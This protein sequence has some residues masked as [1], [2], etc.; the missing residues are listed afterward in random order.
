[1]AVLVGPPGAQVGEV[2]RELGRLTGLPVRDT[3]TDVEETAGCPVAEIFV[4]RGEAEFR[5]LERAAVVD[6]LTGH[7]GVLALG[8]GAVTD[9]RTE[10]DLAGRRVVFLDVGLPDAA[11]RLGFHRD[12]PAGLGN[13][14]AQWLSLMELRRP[15]YQRLA[16]VTVPTDGRTPAEVA[17]AVCEVLGLPA[18]GGTGP[19]G[20]PGVLRGE[21][22]R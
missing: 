2:A 17:L 16:T 10:Q 20:G 21:D 19:G 7:G 22:G 1:M 11:R 14:R 9:P 3:D 4:D 8:G 5:E 13:P 18:I 15:V 12:R 6:A